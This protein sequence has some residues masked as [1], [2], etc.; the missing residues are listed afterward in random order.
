MTLA[1]SWGIQA[2]HEMP[3]LIHSVSFET[4]CTTSLSGLFCTT[5]GIPLA[6]TSKWPKPNKIGASVV[7][8]LWLLAFV[9]QQP[10]EMQPRI[11]QDETPTPTTELAEESTVEAST[12]ETDRTF[13]DAI[14]Q[15][16]AAAEATQTA[17]T[18]DEWKNAA[19]L[20]T[21][22]IDLMESVPETSENYQTSQQKVKEYQPNL[23][24]A[25]NNLNSANLAQ[26]NQSTS[27]QSNTYTKA[28]IALASIQA[29]L[30]SQD[31]DRK[32]FAGAYLLPDSD[33]YIAI[34][35]QPAW[36]LADQ[37]TQEFFLLEMG[38]TW[39]E[40]RSP[41]DPN[42]AMLFVFDVRHE[43]V[44]GRYDAGGVHLNK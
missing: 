37:K 8:G 23:E 19:D 13:A 30:L 1:L 41:D 44:L 22:A 33:Y 4:P 18:S 38:K 7:S 32:I 9:V 28:E 17:K 39:Q 10:N 31:P 14:N 24:Y 2:S 11:A 21:Q 15:A 12:P 27:P 29:H 34:G 20:W 3:L 6:W 36:R 35:V 40:I 42:K 26:E 5:K 25:E 43:E 16:M